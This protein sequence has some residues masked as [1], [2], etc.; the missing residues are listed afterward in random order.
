MKNL[1]SYM[2]F[3]G[4]EERDSGCYQ[5]LKSIHFLKNK[6]VH[7]LLVSILDQ[8]GPGLGSLPKGGTFSGCSVIVGVGARPAATELTGLVTHERDETPGKWAL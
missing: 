4:V 6:R 8:L 3:G 5:F 2:L 1:G 7:E